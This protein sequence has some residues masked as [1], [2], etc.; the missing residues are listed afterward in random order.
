MWA[1]LAFYRARGWAA[2][3][4]L[5]APAAQRAIA[6]LESIDR[7]ELLEEDR[8]ALADATRRVAASR[9]AAASGVASVKAPRLDISHG[10][11]GE[12][13]VTLGEA[14]S[15]VRR[16]TYGV[17]WSGASV[18]SPSGSVVRLSV[19]HTETYRESWTFTR[20]S[21]GWTVRVAPGVPPA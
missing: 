1:A 15:L 7:R 21:R 14:K 12:T 2:K 11:P 13:C 19:Q 9:P 17:V 8:R 4:E 20:G 18:V 10:K 16:C 3:G 6:E 5:A